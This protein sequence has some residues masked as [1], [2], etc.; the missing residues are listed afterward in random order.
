MSGGNVLG[1][2]LV[3]L[4]VD[5]LRLRQWQ[6]EALLQLSDSAD[7]VILNCTNTHFSRRPFRHAFYYLLN[8]LALKNRETRSVR[9]PPEL[10][11][12]E[13]LDFASEWEGAWQRLPRQVLDRLGNWRPD[14][15][16]KFGMGLLKVPEQLDCR[17]LSYHHGDPRRFRGRPGGFFELLGDVPTVGQIVQIISNRLDSGAVVAFGETRARPD[18]YRVTMNDAYR[19]SPLLL[20]TAV[21]NC[22]SGKVLAFESTGKNY[23]LPSN[24]MVARFAAKVTAAKARRLLYGAFFEKAWEVASAEISADSPRELLAQLEDRSRWRIVHRP[25]R[26]RFLADP[27]PHPISGVLVEALR[28]ADEQGEIIH[29]ADE[30]ADVLCHGPGHFSYPATVRLGSEWFIVPEVSEWTSPRAYRLAGEQCELV[31]SLEIEGN[32]RLV[33]PTL[34]TE[35]DT[36]YLFANRAE[37]GSAVLRLWTAP[38]LF[39]RFTEH[40]DSPIRISP[41]GARMGGAILPIGGRL[42]RVGQDCS[43]GYGKGIVLFEIGALS[44]EE[45]REQSVGDFS[46]REVSGPHTFNLR[47]GIALFDFYRE[48]FGALA[49]I[50]RFRARL[51]KRL[52]LS[53]GARNH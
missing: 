39:A 25:A 5:N 47:D 31:G 38:A 24:W 8:V 4:I 16:L 19:L 50:R 37:D 21:R 43:R 9:L 48:R 12:V 14:V 20:R 30:R 42:Y 26:Y 7:F 27:F 3:A 29:I 17:I 2:I 1:R 22:L 6:A 44:P 46:F 18:S 51:A 40:P 52:A 23:R 36:I 13:R 53:S 10:N 41:V 11:V 33:D 45:Y 34:H 28:R 32:P 35:G 49:G 15:A